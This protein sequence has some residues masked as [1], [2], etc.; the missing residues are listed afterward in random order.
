MRIASANAAI[1]LACK[2]FSVDKQQLPGVR[3]KGAL[4]QRMMWD[5]ANLAGAD[6][7]NVNYTDTSQNAFTVVGK[8]NNHGPTN[9]IRRKIFFF[10]VS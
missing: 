5:R 8:D 6:L 1:V 3:L 4:L 2:S 7:R 10:E 9:D